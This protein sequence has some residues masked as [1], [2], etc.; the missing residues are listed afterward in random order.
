[1]KW[2]VLYAYSVT[3]LLW[4]SAFPAIKFGLQ[5]YSPGHLAALRLFIGAI[6]LTVFAVVRKIKL[7]D[8]RDVPAVLLLGFLGFAVYHTALSYGENSVSAGESSLIVSTTPIFSAI[9]AALFLK[10]PLPKIGWLGS[11]IA[12]LGVA[13]ISF[14]KDDS[15]AKLSLGA[16]WILTAALGESF[17]FVFQSKYLKKYGFL[18]FT[19][20]T[21]IA[22]AVCMLFFL[23]G[24]A[25]E[26]LRASA[27]STYAVLYLGLIPTL[28][29][30]FALAYITSIVGASEATSSLYLTPVIALIISWIWLGEIPA[31]LS[32]AG[33]TLALMG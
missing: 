29:P 27:S 25:G 24:L 30:Y 3:V 17:Y 14:G 4:G 8:L 31:F 33:G 23:P 13:M 12:F 18:P 15:L 28:I 5:S 21:I 1:M 2:K 7:P 19:V 11:V 6:G 16:L 20:Y 22:G 26:V 9:L 32:L 10:E